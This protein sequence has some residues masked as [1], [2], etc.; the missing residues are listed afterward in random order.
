MKHTVKFCYESIS[1]DEHLLKL[2][3]QRQWFARTGMKVYIPD[4]LAGGKIIR[5]QLSVSINVKLLRLQSLWRKFE[6][7]FFATMKLLKH[8]TTRSQYIC[9]ATSFG[10]RGEYRP[11]DRI[12]VRLRDTRDDLT[13][14]ETIGHELLHLIYHEYFKSKHLNYEYREGMVDAIIM[15][16]ELH[17]LFPRY[18][19]QSMGKIRPRLL[20][21]LFQNNHIN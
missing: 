11:P 9:Q 4:S 18:T 6:S 16:S 7:N 13:S 17:K 2:I 8:G 14:V 3:C 10:C 5:E 1:E 15:Q 21:A 19:S 20:G 12:I